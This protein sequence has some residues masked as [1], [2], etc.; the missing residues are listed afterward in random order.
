MHK[1]LVLKRMLASVLAASMFITG[2][3]FAD[4]AEG[5][6]GTGDETAVETTGYVKPGDAVSAEDQGEI[7]N[8]DGSAYSR[9]MD[10]YQYILDYYNIDEGT[11]NYNQYLE[12]HGEIGKTQDF[13]VSAVEA[14]KKANH[15]EGMTP[16]VVSVA[17]LEREVYTD[18][19]CVDV[20]AYSEA[21]K[22]D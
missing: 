1:R 21:V 3:A 14:Y 18:G 15:F 9:T 11:L 16:E 13:S 10:D 7:E 4:P 2:I 22:L 20:S 5:T 17:S 19:D 6:S 8:A 12:K